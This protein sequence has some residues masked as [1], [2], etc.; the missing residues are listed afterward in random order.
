MIFLYVP[1]LIRIMTTSTAKTAKFLSFCV[2]LLSLTP[3]ATLYALLSACMQHEDATTESAASSAIHFSNDESL[4][5][6]LQR[7]N[8]TMEEFWVALFQVRMNHHHNPYGPDAF[9]LSS[10]NSSSNNASLLLLRTHLP[11]IF[12][13]LV[14]WLLVVILGIVLP[15]AALLREL[16]KR[17]VYV[18]DKRRRKKRLL[19]C[20]E[21]Y[22]KILSPRD[23]V[24]PKKHDDDDDI[25]HDHVGRWKLPLAGVP[26]PLPLSSPSRQTNRGDALLLERHVVGNCAICLTEYACGETLTWSSN[27]KCVHCFHQD[28]I[29]SWLSKRRNREHTPC[30]CCRQSFVVP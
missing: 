28:C 10:S 9:A 30:P 14:P 2:L 17:G 23:W 6:L 25:Y 8:A 22:K 21:E 5:G 1:A 29:V 11:T 4:A 12:G 3:F 27:S 15:C 26:L 19:K 24:D 13:I 16:Y 7:P 20:L 18:S